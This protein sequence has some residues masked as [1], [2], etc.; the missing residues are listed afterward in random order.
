MFIRR[1]GACHKSAKDELEQIQARQ[2]EL[3]E[4][5]VANLEE[6]LE[7]LAGELSDEEVGRRVRKLLAPHASLEP[8]S[9]RLTLILICKAIYGMS[10]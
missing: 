8:P 9:W 3:S 6:V 5:L 7:L 4:E 2:R 10:Y 1:M